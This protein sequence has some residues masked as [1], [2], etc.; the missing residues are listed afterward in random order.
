MTHGGKREGAGRKPLQVDDARLV[1]AIKSGRT[2]L[3]IAKHFSVSQS[4]V[5]DRSIKL[6]QTTS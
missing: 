4:F 1:T 5:S 6:R 3:D 2:Q